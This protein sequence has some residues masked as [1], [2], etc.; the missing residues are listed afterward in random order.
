MDK[1][2]IAAVLN[3]QSTDKTHRYDHGK[4]MIERGDADDPVEET[5]IRLAILKIFSDQARHEYLLSW[6][7]HALNQVDRYLKGRSCADVLAEF[8]LEK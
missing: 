6:Y 3:I 1:S 5:P 7:G 8:G 2:D 4:D